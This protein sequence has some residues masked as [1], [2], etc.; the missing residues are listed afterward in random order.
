MTSEPD[1]RRR[2]LSDW[3]EQA[4]GSTVRSLRRRPGGGRHEAWDVEL[5]ETGAGT[6]G[7]TGTGTGAE[8]GTGAPTLFLRTD[9]GPLPE[10]ETYT[11]R[12][13]AEIY[14]AVSRVGI[15]VPAIIAVHPEIDAVLME[16]AS[17]AAHFASLSVDAQRAVIDDFVPILVRLHR[18][19]VQAMHLPTLAP[20]R[21]IR[22]HVIDELDTWEHRLDASGAV[23]PFLRA[24]FRYLRDTAP[25]V[26][27]P[28]SLVQGDTGPGNFL[29]DGHRVTAV[30]DFELAHLGDPM[31][32]LAW[33][34]TR[35]A[36]EP[37]P[38]YAALVHGYEAAGGCPVEAERIRYHFLFAELRIAVLAA[39]R[40]SDL[41][42]PLADLGNRLIYGALHTRLTVEALAT[43]VGVELPVVVVDEPGVT[44]ATGYYDAVLS[45]LREVVTPA[46]GDP[47]AVRRAKGLARVVKYL[48]NVDRFGSGPEHAELSAAA[49]VLG[50]RPRSVARAR[51]LLELEVTAG[52][53][54]AV[55]LLPYAWTRVTHDQ[56]R[57]ADSMG[58]LAIRHLP[59]LP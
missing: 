15:P 30:L 35:N 42:D 34:G 39:E 17:G 58:V 43:V 41:P 32:D 47:F 54:D 28:P 59:R 23:E 1:G 25:H 52:R 7:Q 5:A 40:G 2:V 6:H 33:I 21:T 20:V 16:Q 56:A 57:L 48:R 38:D 49:E 27:G 10:Y 37:V 44:E 51:A 11:L 8:T 29:H 22:E 12:R 45:Q 4:T 9:L 53:L 14:R 19:D 24:C 55:A 26:A 36:Q 3:V 31:E 46:I 18:A 13:E 50:V